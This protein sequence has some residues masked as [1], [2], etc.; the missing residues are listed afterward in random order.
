MISMRDHERNSTVTT[1]SMH[2]VTTNLGKCTL[3]IR[4]HLV[5]LYAIVCLFVIFVIYYI[6][7]YQALCLSTITF[8]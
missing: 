4:R 8:L 1:I 2:I 5:K 3:Y 7:V 6:C